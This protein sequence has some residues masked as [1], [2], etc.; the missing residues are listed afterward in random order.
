MNY[1]KQKINFYQ[2]RTLGENITTTFDFLKDNWK[3]ILKL[4]LY[5]LL[6]LS[7]VQ[8]VFMNNFTS[9]VVD[10]AMYP[11]TTAASFGGIV[12]LLL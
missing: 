8:G 3:L 9:D 12:L 1:Q 7:I 10:A 2:K 4:C 11:P 5:V 6:P